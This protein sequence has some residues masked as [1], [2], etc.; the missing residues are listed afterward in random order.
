MECIAFLTQKNSHVAMYKTLGRRFLLFVSQC[1]LWRN[2]LHRRSWASD[3][4]Q[5]G[6]LWKGCSFRTLPNPL[7]NFKS[8]RRFAC[9]GAKDVDMTGDLNFCEV[10]GHLLGRVGSESVGRGT[11]SRL[12]PLFNK[13][14]NW[15][16]QASFMK[17]HKYE[18]TS[19]WVDLG[20]TPAQTYSP[21]HDVPVT[22]APLHVCESDGI[23]TLFFF[24]QVP[25]IFCEHCCN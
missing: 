21:M 7:L 17:V 3:P 25:I 24:N 13:L 8:M 6:M 10:R 12:H 2:V 20:Q 11:F 1:A 4:H 23:Y 15:S 16:S 5:L 19:Q 18:T 14:T 9:C 22:L